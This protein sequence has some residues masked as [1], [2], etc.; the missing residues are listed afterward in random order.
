MTY[1]I[2]LP[3][4]YTS[5]PVKYATRVIHVTEEGKRHDV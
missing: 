5:G 3:H 1:E 2:L 4:S